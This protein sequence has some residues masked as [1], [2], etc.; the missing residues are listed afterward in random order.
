MTQETKLVNEQIQVILAGSIYVED[1]RAM[2]ESLTALIEKGQNTFL[3]D[4]AQVDYIDSTGLGMLISI[5][6]HA[7]KN[8]GNVSLLGIQGI[9]KEVFELTLLTKVFEIEQ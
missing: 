1:A 3:I 4:L 6:K 9:V 8:G 7:M 2:R 5:K